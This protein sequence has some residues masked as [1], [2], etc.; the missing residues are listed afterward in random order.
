MEAPRELSI[1]D[2]IQLSLSVFLQLTLVVAAGFAAWHSQWT[3]VFASVL[4]L[5]VTFFPAIIYRSIKVYFPAEFIL[6]LTLFAYAAVFL[7]EVHGFYTKFWWWDLVLHGASGVTLGFT[8]FLILYTLY[9]GGRLNMTPAL[10][11]I[12]SFTFAL[13]LGALWEIFEFS[14]DTL[15]GFNMQKNGLPD[16]MWDLIVDSIGA[17]IVVVVGYLYIRKPRQG[18]FSYLIS[19]FFAQNPRFRP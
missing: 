8:G 17:L 3:A 9:I 2:K 14:M 11:S 18:L 6:V 1:F 7:G 5:L 4:A 16:T 10:L 19:K 15:F 13:A 12:F